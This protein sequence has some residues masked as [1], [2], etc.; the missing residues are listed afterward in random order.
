ML[1]T[2]IWSILVLIYIAIT[3]AFLPSIFIPLASLVALCLTTLFWFAGSITMAVLIGVPD[4]NG[5]NFCQSAQ[6][7]VAFGFFNWIVFTG[8]A[9]V[10][11]MGFM[12]SRGHTGAN[13][14][15]RSKGGRP[16]SGA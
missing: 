16:Y 6:A 15:V 3:P 7:G 8:L 5:S 2:T 9:V 13:A 4:C 11:V 10:E 12:R 1:F 14:D